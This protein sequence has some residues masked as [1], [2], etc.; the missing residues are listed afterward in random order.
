MLNRIIAQVVSVMPQRLI[1]IF[2]KRYIAGKYL[3]DAIKVSKQLNKKNIS[4]TIDV[5]GEYIKDLQEAEQNTQAFIET[6]DAI[7]T[8]K[9]NSTVSIK[10]TMFGLLIDKDFCVD[11]IVKIIEK[12]KSLNISVCLDMEDSSCTDTE[13][14]M[15]KDLYRKY[16]AHVSFVVQ[17]YLHRTLKDLKDLATANNIEHP[18]D[19]RLCKGIYKEKVDVAFQKRREINNNFMS[20]LKFMAENNFFCSI[21]THDKELVSAAQQLIKE[22]KLPK[23]RYEFQM[24]YGVSPELRKSINEKKYPLRVYVPYG[25]QWFGYSTRRLKE[26]PKMVTHIIKSLFI[27]N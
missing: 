25:A 11:Q 17:A 23:E 8:N 22:Q 14:T 24:L 7:S 21:A 26:N 20:C 5:L 19:I 10:P 16:P 4:A 6:I 15:F 27:R 18:I 1:W 13:I 12:A 3:E 9:V 2:S